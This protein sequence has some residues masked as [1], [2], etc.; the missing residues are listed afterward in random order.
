MTTKELIE[1][2]GEFPGDMPVMVCIGESEMA[3]N[4]DSVDLM[5]GHLV[6]DDDDTKKEFVQLW[7]E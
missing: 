4:I 1:K 7:S 5:E 6:E 3:S 2:L